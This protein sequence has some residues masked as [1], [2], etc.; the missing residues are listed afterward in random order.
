R[1]V[2]QMHWGGGTPTYLD[3]AQVS[4]LVTLLKT[5]FHFSDD[6]EMSIEVDPREIELDMI[7][8]LRSEGFNRLSMGVQ[9]FNK[10]VQVLVNREQDEDFIFALINRAKETGF[11]S[12]SIDLI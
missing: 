10:D 1:T 5:H 9:D 2:T 12:T 11:T 7:D 8:H 3:K 6:V 4:H